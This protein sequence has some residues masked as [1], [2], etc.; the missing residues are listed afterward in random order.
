MRIVRKILHKRYL[1]LI[2]YTPK[3]TNLITLLTSSITKIL[4]VN[5]ELE[6]YCTSIDIQYSIERNRDLEPI[7]YKITPLHN[8]IIVVAI[9]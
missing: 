6:T 4:T 3:F 1:K 5:I 2:Y 9:C 8:Y 7:R